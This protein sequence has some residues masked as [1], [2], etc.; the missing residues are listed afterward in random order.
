MR[1]SWS[2][3]LPNMPRS[4]SL[5][6]I[7]L[8]QTISISP[9]CFISNC[10]VS[11]KKRSLGSEPVRDGELTCPSNPAGLCFS[12]GLCCVQGMSDNRVGDVLSCFLGGCYADGGCLPQLKEREQDQVETRESVSKRG[13]RLLYGMAPPQMNLFGQ[14]GEYLSFARDLDTDSD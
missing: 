8:A 14:A 3:Q 1:T 9:G 2:V 12:P 6:I 4:C 11:G 5:V 7:V 10:P 13:L